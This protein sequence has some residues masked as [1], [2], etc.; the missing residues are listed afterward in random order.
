M[1]IVRTVDNPQ[2]F[3]DTN[4]HFHIKMLL[5]ALLGWVHLWIAGL[6]SVLGGVWRG[7][8]SGIQDTA[9]IISIQSITIKKTPKVVELKHMSAYFFILWPLSQKIERRVWCNSLAR[10]LQGQLN[11]VV[12]YVSC[13]SGAGTV[14][15]CW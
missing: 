8:N 4:M 13:L 15:F 14:G 1:C 5:I 3:I 2:Y 12:F 6:F 7:N 11:T 10:I 9:L